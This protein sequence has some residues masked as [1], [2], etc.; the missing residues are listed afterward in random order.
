MENNIFK[1]EKIRSHLNITLFG[2]KL[3]ILLKNFQKERTNFKK[4]Y[5][6]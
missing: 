1:I 3:N 2:I 6:S 4:I 5:Q